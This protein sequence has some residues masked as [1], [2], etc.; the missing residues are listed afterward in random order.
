MTGTDSYAA[1]LRVMAR[2]RAADGCPW[3]REQTHESLRPY[4]L[5]ETYEALEAID[6]RDSAELCKELGDV[7]LQIVF[8]A[9][10]ASEAGQFSMRD[11]CQA[12]VDKLIH[13]HPHVFA[14]TTVDG[15]DQVLSNWERLKKEEKSPSAEPHSVLDGVPASLPALLRAQRVQARASRSGF[16]WERVDG[17]LDKVEEEFRELR[18]EWEHGEQARAEEEM[19]DLLFALVNAARFLRINP[20][21]ALRAAVAKFERRFRAVE[22]AF[23]ERGRELS[24][25][26]LKEMDAVWDDVKSGE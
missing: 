9:Q 26:S 10:I 21:D 1:L 15:A 4:L 18:T 17:P 7:L 8:H 5:E 12:I 23:Q 25:A 20:E 14:D 6:R 2:L 16:D 19:G 24:N 22:A 11:V 3:D 13:R